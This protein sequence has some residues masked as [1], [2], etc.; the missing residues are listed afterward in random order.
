MAQNLFA[1]KPFK[2]KDVSAYKFMRLEAL[3]SE[4]GNFGNSFQFESAFS[5]QQWLDRVSNPNGVCF[6]LYADGDLI[7]ITSIILTNAE[8]SE[9]AYMTQ[10]YIRK[11]Y[12]KLGLSKLFFEERIKWARERN[13]K[14]LIIGHRESNQSSKQANQKFGF[15]YTHQEDHTW[16]DG[17]TEPMLY[18][19]LILKDE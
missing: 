16:P 4:P 18:Y 17:T 7:G 5:D 14:R 2:E 3:K 11:D 8:N 12:R 15:K 1:I 19:E 13:L 6:G 10:S 9:E